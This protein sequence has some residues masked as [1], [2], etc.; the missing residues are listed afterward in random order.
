MIRSFPDSRTQDL[1]EDGTGERLPHEIIHRAVRKLEFI[2]L[3]TNL[4]D[5]KVPRGN[6]LHA[7]S[8]DRS[9]F[10]AIAV[11]DRWRICFRFVDGDAFDVEI[12]DHH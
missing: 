11:N 7:F 1:F 6:R 10:L 8:G 4:N 3:A 9:G 12:C 5:L 2:D